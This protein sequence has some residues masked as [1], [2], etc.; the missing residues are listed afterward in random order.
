MLVL[1]FLICCVLIPRGNVRCCAQV[2]YHFLLLTSSYYSSCAGLASW[3]AAVGVGSGC[4]L[5][6]YEP[7]LANCTVV[8][9]SL[10]GT[11]QLAATYA[12][13]LPTSKVFLLNPDFS[14]C[15]TKLLFLEHALRRLPLIC[16]RRLSDPRSSR[17][18]QR[19]GLH[20][21]L[22]ATVCSA[23]HPLRRTESPPPPP[24]VPSL[25][26]GPHSS[27]ARETNRRTSAELL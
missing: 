13:V 9:S 27:C 22:E 6:R 14:Y 7:H 5:P 23:L 19:K 12:V 4:S 8:K 16:R 1:Q 25:H 24:L 10:I 2:F 20:L 18:A 11:V 17:I 21:E 3:S 15:L 26:R